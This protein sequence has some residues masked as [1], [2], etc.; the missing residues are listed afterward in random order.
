[1]ARGGI[2]AVRE[3]GDYRWYNADHRRSQA[4]CR[5]GACTGQGRRKR[6]PYTTRK[7]PAA[8]Q[9]DEN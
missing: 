9:K 6:R 7:I 3:E 4:R 2:F 5:A 8:Q 1:M